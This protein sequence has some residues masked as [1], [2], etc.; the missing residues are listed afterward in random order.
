MDFFFERLKINQKEESTNCYRTGN[1]ITLKII[2]TGSGFTTKILLCQVD[3]V[4]KRAQRAADVYKSC[5]I[6]VHG[7][8]YNDTRERGNTDLSQ[9]IRDWVSRGKRSVNKNMK[10]WLCLSFVA[11]L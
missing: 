8:F 7:C 11:N 6:Y 1:G 4:H 5:F 9:V 2:P 10:I 3:L